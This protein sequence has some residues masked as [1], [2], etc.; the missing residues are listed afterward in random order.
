MKEDTLLGTMNVRKLLLKTGIPMIL[1][2][3]LQAVYNIVDSAFVSNMTEGGEQALCALTLAFPVQI[4]MV[5]LG[6]GTGVGVN[7]FV[8]R[9]LGSGDKAKAAHIAG[10]GIVLA[11]IIY[12]AF[13]LF[14]LFG[15]NAYVRSL[16][17]DATTAQMTADYLH[18][19][20]A[21]SAG[22]VFFSIFEKLLQSTGLSLYST[23]AQVS[24]ALTNI[25]LDPVMIYGLLG[26]PALAVKGAAYATVIGQFVSLAVAL[27]LH[28]TKNRAIRLTLSSFSPS[29]SLIRAIYA[30]GFPAI[31]AQALM[32]MM[33]YGLNV[34][35][36]QLGSEL[37]TAY[38]LYYKIQQFILFMAFGLRDA[39][40]PV[41]AFNFGKKDFARVNDGIK[42]GL[43][44]T[45][46]LMFCGLLLLEIFAEPF[47]SLFSLSKSTELLCVLAMRIVSISFLFAGANIALQGVFQALGNGGASLI[48]SLLR[49]LAVVL[50]AAYALSL[51]AK[52]TGN[53]AA[54]FFAFLIAESI[55]LAA[56]FPLLHRTGLHIRRVFNL[57]TKKAA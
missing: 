20:C 30:I 15:V 47:A 8:S 55:S 2:M 40:M 28:C 38:G 6:I 23:I 21:Y 29:A 12:A 25:V 33:T 54:V 46:F 5:A 4:L 42:Y 51:I 1:S 43:L 57:T 17:A 35:F 37:V 10:N 3:A 39:I 44:Y 56:A 52:A 16:T 45:L 49:Q 53:T 18:I 41:V 14:A 32:S 31:V 27:A 19:C 11:L 34:I 26:F 7:V 50:P 22:I 9:T 13:L 48:I 36:A 24:G